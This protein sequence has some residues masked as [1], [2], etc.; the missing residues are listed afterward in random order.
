MI[1][2]NKITYHSVNNSES[3]NRAVALSWVT[4]WFSLYDATQ[5]EIEK[6]RFLRWGQTGRH[7]GESGK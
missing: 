7:C 3:S 4:E 6:A 5:R 2:R 1:G